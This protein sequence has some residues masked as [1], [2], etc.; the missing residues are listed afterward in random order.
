LFGGSS[1]NFCH[2]IVH[3]F[4]RID[5]FFHSIARFAYQ[6][7]AVINFFAPNLKSAL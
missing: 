6:L 1:G 5:D 4:N 3:P 2:N 7:I